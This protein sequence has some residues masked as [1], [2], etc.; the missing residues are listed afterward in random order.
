MKIVVLDAQTLGAD[1]DLSPL[2]A[3]GDVTV[4]DLTTPEQL[5]ERIRDAEVLVINKPKLHAGNL[6][7]ARSLKLIC[8]CGTGYDNVDIPYCRSRSIGVCNVPG[9][10][11]DSVA[12]LTVAMV[13]SLANHLPEYRSFVHSGE[14]AGGTAANRLT[15]VWH[16]LAGKTWG[17]LGCGSIGGQVARIAEALGCRVLAYHRDSDLDSILYQSDILSIHLPLNDQTRGLI[18][19]EKIRLMKPGAI[20]VNAARGA[21]ADEAALA[22]AILTGHLGGLGVDVYS[23]EPFP[24]D[25]PYTQLLELP[26]VVLT[27]HCGWGSIEARNRC[28]AIVADNIRCYQQNRIKNRVDVV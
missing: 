14:Y 6:T 1:T 26:N 17:I 25:H 24:A 20:L 7:C 19:G 22:E 9:Y 11:R 2:H 21:V 27:P 4:Y 5:P 13:L 28:L 3:A 8:V 18:S 10:S 12:Q 23:R 15:P 16:E